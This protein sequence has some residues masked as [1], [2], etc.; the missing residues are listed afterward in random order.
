MAT[1]VER[2]TKLARPTTASNFMRIFEAQLTD[3]LLL[4]LLLRIVDRVIDNVMGAKLPAVRAKVAQCHQMGNYFT[5][6]SNMKL[7]V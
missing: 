7:C 3:T 4:L 1:S 2:M 5:H 6:R